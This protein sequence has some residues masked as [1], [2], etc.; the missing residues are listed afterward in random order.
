LLQAEVDRRDMDLVNAEI[1]AYRAE[2][3]QRQH[4]Q[5]STQ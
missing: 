1:H 4:D 5:S 2:K 3:G